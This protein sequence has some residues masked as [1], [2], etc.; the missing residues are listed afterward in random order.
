MLHGAYDEGIYEGIH[1]AYDEGIYFSS[2]AHEPALFYYTLSNVKCVTYIFISC[3]PS[4]NEHFITGAESAPE[5]GGG[6]DH[7]RVK[8]RAARRGAT[9]PLKGGT[10]RGIDGTGTGAV[11]LLLLRSA[12]KGDPGGRASPKSG[13]L[14][15]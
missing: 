11:H 7:R 1:G 10:D 2:E 14:K 5:D 8:T 9:S 13:D 3:T 4:N 15:G 6:Q 12:G